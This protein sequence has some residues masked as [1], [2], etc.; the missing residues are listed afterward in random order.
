MAEK[1]GKQDK[2]K[3]KELGRENL[4][5]T[6]SLLPPSVCACLGFAL[7][8]NSFPMLGINNQDIKADRIHSLPINSVSLFINKD[9]NLYLFPP[10][11]LRE[12]HI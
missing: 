3:Q 4:A 6:K 9:E 8:T 2:H 10:S 12:K 1:S 11:K 7:Y 5:R